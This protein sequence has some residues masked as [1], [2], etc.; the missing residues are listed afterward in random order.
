MYVAPN[1]SC[2]YAVVASSVGDGY[3]IY[4]V[5]GLDGTSHM[6]ASRV[7][8]LGDEGGLA[9]YTPQ[10]I[11]RGRIMLMAANYKNASSLRQQ[12]SRQDREEPPA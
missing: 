1:T 5:H 10:T 9:Y 8:T 6:L 3:D 11:D 7:S 2:R 4:A 12:L